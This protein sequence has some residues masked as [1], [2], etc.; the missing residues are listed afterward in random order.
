MGCRAIITA[1]TLRCP[2]SYFDFGR[3]RGVGRGSVLVLF[4][5]FLRHFSIA[6]TK[7]KPASGKHATQIPLPTNHSPTLKI[8][9]SAVDLL[10]TMQHSPAKRSVS[11][12][13]ATIVSS[14]SGK[15]IFS[16]TPF[17]SSSII[18]LLLFLDGLMWRFSLVHRRLRR[19]GRLRP[20][21]HEG[22]GSSRHGLRSSINPSR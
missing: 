19:P 11:G 8:C 18:I 21:R 3:I 20:G 13:K 14:F 15:R 6:K 12:T 16:I 9:R 2:P 22:S 10:T 5:H 17:L 7:S 1:R 4:T